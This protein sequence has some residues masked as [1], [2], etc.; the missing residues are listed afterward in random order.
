VNFVVVF[1]ELA[2]KN[3]G[4]IDNDV[5]LK[6]EKQSITWPRKK[7]LKHLPRFITKTFCQK[8]EGVHAQMGG[9]IWVT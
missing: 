4:K 3:L 2:P 9:P 7:E 6:N 5:T 8:N 1:K